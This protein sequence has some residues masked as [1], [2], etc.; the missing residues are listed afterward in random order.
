MS[1]FPTSFHLAVLAA[2]VLAQ[3]PA[4]APAPAVMASVEQC[5][6]SVNQ[7]E[8]SATFVAQMTAVQGT[9]HM[10][11]R[12]E[13]QERTPPDETFH[14]IVAPGLGMW[15]SSEP[16]VKVYKYVKELTNLAAPAAFR[17]QVHYRWLD[18]RGRVIKRAERRSPACLQPV[19]IP[20]PPA[21]M[22]EA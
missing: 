18:N 21:R 22:P 11:M 19:D 3:A 2:G 13:V 9:Q 20:Q 15:R 6:P 17:V 5:T 10:A 7:A 1:M 4:P 8:R 12:I 16:G 14:T